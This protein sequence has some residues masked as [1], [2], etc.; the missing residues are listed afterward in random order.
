MLKL[1]EQIYGA[2]TGAGIDLGGGVG[3]VSSCV[4]K[5]ESVESVICLEITENTVKECHPIVILALLKDKHTKVKSVIGDFDNLK[6]P[7]HTLDFAIAWDSIHHSNDV[8]KTLSEVHRVLKHEGRMII[9]DRG[10]NNSTS[11]A[12]IERMLN[13]TYPEEFLVSNYLPKD[14]SL[15]RRENGEHEYRYEQWEKFF[16]SSGFEVE[17]SLIVKEKH[18]KT[19]QR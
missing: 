8:V 16:I 1:S 13:V 18:T 3:T 12:E 10:H 15:T 2:M 5:S 9:I 7:N 11:D 19:L 6:L 17:H 4:A 14:K